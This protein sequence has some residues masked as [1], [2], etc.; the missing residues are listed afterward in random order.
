MQ[1]SS[2]ATFAQRPNTLFAPRSP[3]LNLIEIGQP[4]LV[5]QGRHRSQQL[6]LTLFGMR[7]LRKGCI[8]STLKGGDN[9]RVEF[10][11]ACEM[12]ANYFSC[13]PTKFLSGHVAFK[14]ALE[15][16]HQQP[17]L[18]VVSAAHMTYEKEN[19]GCGE[20]CARNDEGYRIDLHG[21]RFRIR[22]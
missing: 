6:P 2:D 4:K 17:P 9:E 5:F 20:Q 12:L 19:E 18:E 3:R 10:V 7:L 8:N 16:V 22:A 11:A 14:V 15:Q 21:G 13:A 1:P